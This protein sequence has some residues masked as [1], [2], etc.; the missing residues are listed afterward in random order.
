MFFS[1]FCSFFHCFFAKLVK[2]FVLK[3]HLC[4]LK[5]FLLKP[6]Q[7]AQLRI[8]LEISYYRYTKLYK[9]EYTKWKITYEPFLLQAKTKIRFLQWNSVNGFR[10]TTFTF[11]WHMN[12]YFAVLTTHCAGDKNIPFD[13]TVTPQMVV[14]SCRIQLQFQ[15]L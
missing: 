15:M 13:P 3:F 4:L 5:N 6:A 10:Q 1:V 2:K 14:F 7:D 8:N 11:W 12:R 9:A